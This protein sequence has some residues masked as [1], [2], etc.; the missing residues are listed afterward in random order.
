[1]VSMLIQIISVQPAKTAVNVV[2]YKYE[3]SL[4]NLRKEESIKIKLISQCVPA[5]YS[6]VSNPNVPKWNRLAPC[7]FAIYLL[8]NPLLISSLLFHLWCHWWIRSRSKNL[9]VQAKPDMQWIAVDSSTWWIAE[10]EL[11]HSH[12]DFANQMG[13]LNIFH[14]KS[15][16]K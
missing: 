13:T 5:V 8:P 11:G 10:W 14:L 15:N 2:S 6:T 9:Q 4:I 7:T 3:S 16:R 12:T 1:M